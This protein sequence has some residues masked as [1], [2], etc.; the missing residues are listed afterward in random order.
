M[1]GTPCRCP[2]HARFL[3][4]PPPSLS[5]LSL[6]HLPDTLGPA[7]FDLSGQAPSEVEGGSRVF[8]G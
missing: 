7:I 6:T 5:T 8:R 2:A 1:H 3:N 4:P